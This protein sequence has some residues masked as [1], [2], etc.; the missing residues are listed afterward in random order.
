MSFDPKIEKA[1][2]ITAFFPEE[3]VMNTTES[4]PAS[5]A[6]RK[7]AQLPAIESNFNATEEMYCSHSEIKHA[8]ENW[9][10]LEALLMSAGG[11]NNI[12]V[13]RFNHPISLS[14][15]KGI[16][17][18]IDGGGILWTPFSL[19]GMYEDGDSCDNAIL[20]STMMAFTIEHLWKGSFDASDLEYSHN[21]VSDERL[22]RIKKELG[23]YAS[24]N[25][26]EEKIDSTF[27]EDDKAKKLLEWIKQSGLSILKEGLCIDPKERSYLRQPTV[28]EIITNYTN[29]QSISPWHIVKNPAL[30]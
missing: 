6:G 19:R 24:C 17:V 8:I 16:W 2:S 26:I 1:N 10:K 27:T 14:Y 3:P 12:F 20:S 21:L 11:I 28:K 13:V 9:G 30:S 5:L 22:D 23:P 15:N 18:N 29:Q 25:E 4:S 7:A